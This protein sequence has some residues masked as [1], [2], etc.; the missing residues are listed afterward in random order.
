MNVWLVAA[1]YSQKILR[2]VFLSAGITTSVMVRMTPFRRK[3]VNGK[4]PK[5]KFWLLLGFGLVLNSNL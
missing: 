5:S 3:T 2:N 1:G 4:L